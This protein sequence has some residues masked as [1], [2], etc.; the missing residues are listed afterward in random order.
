MATFKFSSNLSGHGLLPVFYEQ[1]SM[2]VVST[3]DTEIVSEDAQ[4]DHVV[5]QGSDLTGDGTV[6]KILFYNASDELLLT[7]AGNFDPADLSFDDMFQD[8][9]TLQAGRDKFVGSNAADFMLYGQN[10]GKDTLLGRGGNDTLL[11]SSG[12]NVYDGGKGRSDTLSFDV[13]LPLSK[14]SAA[15]T[16]GIKVDLLHGKVE[17]AWGGTDKIR[18]I[19][20]VQGTFEKDV[21]IGGRKS[22]TFVGYDGN[23][24]YTG[25]LGNDRFSFGPQ[26]GKDVFTDFGKGRDRIE[27]Y[28]FD[29]VD[30]FAELKDYMHQRGKNAVIEFSDHDSLTFLHTRVSELHSSQFTFLDFI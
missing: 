28:G 4:G 23:D 1:A 17:N 13:A 18:N 24:R 27:I 6:S 21:F 14:V 15:A 16:T 19:E 20:V 3:S 25:G 29:P 9:V 8:I 30:T 2:Q 26:D 10:A 11:A 22:D 7:V 12:N 5:F